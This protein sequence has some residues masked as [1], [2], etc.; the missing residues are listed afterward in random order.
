MRVTVGS[1]EPELEGGVVESPK[2]FR[3][4]GDLVNDSLI[5]MVH[6]VVKYSRKPHVT[7]GAQKGGTFD[8]SVL[9]EK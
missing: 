3:V 4:E 7:I 8:G 6:L 5:I 1:P 9:D 2:T